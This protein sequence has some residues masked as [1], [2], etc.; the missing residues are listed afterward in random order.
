[1]AFFPFWGSKFPLFRQLGPNSA[2]IKN[3]GFSKQIFWKT[4]NHHETDI[5]GQQEPQTR[6]FSYHFWGLFL[7]FE[8]QNTKNAETPIFAVFW[9]KNSKII[10]K[11]GKFEK[12]PIFPPPP[13]IRKLLDHWSPKK[14]Q[15]ENWV[16]K[17]LL[18]PLLRIGPKSPW[19]R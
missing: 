5:F 11:T 4:E 16:C 1:M 10:L 15:N 2:H 17:K 14:T 9:Q 3:R 7:L 12:T 8:H 6:N 18:E 19:T 13:K